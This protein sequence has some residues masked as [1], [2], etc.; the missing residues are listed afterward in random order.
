[1]FAPN[2]TWKTRGKIGSFRYYVFTSDG[3]DATL[4]HL[5]SGASLVL[6]SIVPWVYAVSYSGKKR[7]A[8]INAPKS[9]VSRLN[10]EQLGTIN[11]LYIQAKTSRDLPRLVLSR[12]NSQQL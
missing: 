7:T 2:P 12:G 5:Y 10:R 3:S 4:M 6:F 11:W 9:V 1:M 8:A